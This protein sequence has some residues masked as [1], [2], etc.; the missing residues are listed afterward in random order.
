MYRDDLCTYI[1]YSEQW[2][3]NSFHFRFYFVTLSTNAKGSLTYVLM[4]DE[5]I[6]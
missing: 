6:T 3:E 4:I 1:M 2:K 5:L